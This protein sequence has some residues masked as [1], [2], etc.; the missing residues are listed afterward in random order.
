MYSAAAKLCRV[1]PHLHPSHSDVG[2]RP[3][4]YL[5]RDRRPPHLH[6]RADHRH[7]VRALP[8]DGEARVG[9]ARLLEVLPSG[10]D[11]VLLRLEGVVRLVSLERVVAVVDLLP[12][13]EGEAV[14]AVGRVQG[15][16]VVLLQE[17]GVRLA[18][19]FRRK[20]E[21]FIRILAG[22][23]ATLDCLKNEK[24]HVSSELN[25]CRYI[26]GEMFLPVPRRA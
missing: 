22:E 18:L 5:R 2:P 15:A 19:S 4:V 16:V 17:V 3:V 12:Q 10:A 1:S 25:I 14:L 11:D 21:K 7:Q 6:P 13:R 8:E 9:G 23:N 24:S 26:T 20:T